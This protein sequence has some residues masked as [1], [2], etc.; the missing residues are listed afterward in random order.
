M[1]MIMQKES[2]REREREREISNEVSEL[3]CFDLKEPVERI[4]NIIHKLRTVSGRICTV[5]V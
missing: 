2:K 5:T 1:T 4:V 3:V